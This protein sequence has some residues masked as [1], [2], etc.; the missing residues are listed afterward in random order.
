[1]MKTVSC[2]KLLASHI[3]TTKMK[4]AGLRTAKCVPLRW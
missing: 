3:G 4:S 1:M 2:V